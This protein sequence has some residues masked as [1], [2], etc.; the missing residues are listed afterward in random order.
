LTQSFWSNRSNVA[1]SAAGPTT[2]RIRSATRRLV[3]RVG[4]IGLEQ[5]AFPV[6]RLERRDR[7]LGNVKDLADE[8]RHRARRCVVGDEPHDVGRAVRV[9]AFEHRLGLAL[10]RQAR[11][12]AAPQGGNR[13]RAS[14]I[15]ARNRARRH[16]RASHKGSVLQAGTDL[17]RALSRIAGAPAVAGNQVGVL[18]DAGENYP[19]WLDA[20]AS[21]ER[22]IHFENFIIADD[23]TGWLFADALAARARAGVKVRVLYDWLGSCFRASS[24]LWAALREAGVE[25]R[26]FNP[27]GLTSPLWI[28]R[29]HRKLI[30]VDGRV[31]FVSGLCVSDNWLGDRS[32]E[33]WRDTGVE[34]RG[35]AVA[36]STAPSPR[37]GARP[38][39]RSARSTDILPRPR[40]PPGDVNMRVVV[41]RPGQLSLYRL[42]LLVAASAKTDLVAD[43]R[44]FRA[45]RRLCAGARRSRPRRRRRAG[46]DPGHER[47]AGP[48]H[49]RPV[50]LPAR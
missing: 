13:R 30:T 24:R 46:A 42:D 6:R 49:A 47:R 16:P 10:A 4:E 20:I 7:R 41:G 1:W 48:A 2:G 26:A 23:T 11:Q 5:P 18:C 9:E 28:R 37:P 39:R 15:V 19:A 34:I 36:S 50:G 31:G 12:P 21:A 17:Q 25:V 14:A 3:G 33:P 22:V 38:A 44:L 35:P 45:D 8:V 43:R 40:R 29:N 27:P 32:G